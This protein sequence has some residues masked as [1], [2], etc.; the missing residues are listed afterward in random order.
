MSSLRSD[1]Q[2]GGFTLTGTLL[3]TR[4]SGDRT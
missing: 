3:A 1:Q 2:G 4:V